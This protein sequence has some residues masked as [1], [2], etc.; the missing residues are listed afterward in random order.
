MP[1][2]SKAIQQTNNK[3]KTTKIYV[4]EQKTDLKEW[5]LYSSFYSLP[6]P[7]T[8]EGKSIVFFA[9]PVIV[10][11]LMLLWERVNGMDTQ[12]HIEQIRLCSM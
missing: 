11:E 5:D 10:S 3:E 9:K 1:K 2:Q 7:L 8:L 6:L 4:K 12:M